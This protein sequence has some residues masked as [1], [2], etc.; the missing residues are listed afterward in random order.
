ML[1]GQVA[2]GLASIAADA[3]KLFHGVLL[4]DEAVAVIFLYFA[5]SGWWSDSI[6][7]EGG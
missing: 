7:W 5:V 4:S 1:P 3:K 6:V 2:L